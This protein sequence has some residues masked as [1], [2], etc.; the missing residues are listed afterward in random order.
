MNAKRCMIAAPA[1][2]AAGILNSGLALSAATADSAPQI[3]VR[4]GD[5][6]LGTE[7]GAARLLRRISRAAAQVC[8]DAGRDL[9]LATVAS[10]CRAAAVARAVEAVHNLRLTA[11]H[12]TKSGVG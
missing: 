6:D 7:D 12:A 11:L 8:P 10:E 9:R 2:A 3:A 4:Y 5:L 1:L